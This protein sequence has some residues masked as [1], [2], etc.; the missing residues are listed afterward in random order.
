MNILHIASITEF[1]Y[2]GVCV[3]VPKH[4]IEQSRV[5]N[6]AFINVNNQRIEELKNYQIDYKSPFSIGNIYAEYIRPDIVIFHECYRVEYLKIY[7]IL[8]KENIP[9]IIIPH[10]ELSVE[11][12]KHKLIKKKIANIL[13]FN[14]FISKATGIQCLSEREKNNTNFKCKKFIATNGISIPKE[15]KKEFSDS[16]IKFVYIGRIDSYHKGLD[17]LISAIA[18]K[19][20]LLRQNRC[21]FDLYG[22]HSNKVAESINEMIR[23]AGVTDIVKLHDGV[24]GNEKISILL[25]SDIFVQASRFEGMPLGILEALSYGL[26][27]LVTQG[28][29]LGE[30]IEAN[31]A[32]WMAKTEVNSLAQALQR[33]IKDKSQ[34]FMRGKAARN[35]IK[36]NYAW[37]MI[38]ERTVKE[39]ENMICA[40]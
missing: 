18:K 23:R 16:I 39:Y 6:V 11:A 1:A 24:S 7:P 40:K 20:E 34:Y 3:V 12:Q 33:V 13:L 26:P 8:L 37:K 31:C 22:P 4:V 36:N 28:T 38:A 10:G 25:E 17:I 29:T 32:G 30:E 35:F 27:C 5:A 14:R 9:Y 21:F 15:I 2:S 19:S